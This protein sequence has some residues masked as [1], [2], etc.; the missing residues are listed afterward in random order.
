MGQDSSSYLISECQQVVI[1]QN[2]DRCVVVMLQMAVKHGWLPSTTQVEY[3]E[4]K[5]VPTV[6]KGELD[7]KETRTNKSKPI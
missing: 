7:S 2:R 3:L 6:V 5:P 1:D 4:R